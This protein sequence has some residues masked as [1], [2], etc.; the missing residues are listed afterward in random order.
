MSS[1]HLRSCRASG[2]KNAWRDRRLFVRAPFDPSL[3]RLLL[4]APGGWPVGLDYTSGF[5]KINNPD[6]FAP[7][8]LPDEGARFDR[9]LD[10]CHIWNDERLAYLSAELD[11]DTLARR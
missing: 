1:T 7:D 8:V 11:T 4:I 9:R 3:A 6:R 10:A 5:S 2:T